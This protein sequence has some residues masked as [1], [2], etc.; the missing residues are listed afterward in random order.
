MKLPSSG[1]FYSFA[2]SASNLVSSLLLNL[3]PNPSDVMAKPKEQ[4][5][6]AH[7]YGIKFEPAMQRLLVKNC[8]KC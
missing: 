2:V 7:A 8:A 3:V 4:P 5:K 1:L 6:N